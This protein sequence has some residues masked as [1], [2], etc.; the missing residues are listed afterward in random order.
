MNPAHRPRRWVASIRQAESE[1]EGTISSDWGN[2]IQ[3]LSIIVNYCKKFETLLEREFQAKGRGLHE[4]ITSA[5]ECLSYELI[6]DLRF[7]ATIRNKALHEEDYN[8]IDDFDEL[9]RRCKVIEKELHIL[10]QESGSSLQKVM[11]DKIQ[12]P[13]FT[14][15]QNS[16]SL[17][18]AHVESDE[19]EQNCDKPSL[20]Y[21]NECLNELLLVKE[22]KARMT[23]EAK[24]YTGLG[25]VL[26][27]IEQAQ[28]LRERTERNAQKAKRKAQE[29]I[30]RRSKQQ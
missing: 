23:S 4:K 10:T 21:L 17:D 9:T 15:I 18:G 19:Q 14:N 16:N 3:E 30:I 1:S 25:I 2:L 27:R 20:E 13:D 22:E 5:Q 29:A 12:L 11:P 8:F 24:E 6:K 26:D 7:V 28:Q